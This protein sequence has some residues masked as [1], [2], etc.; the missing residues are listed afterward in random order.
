MDV[1]ENAAFMF[2]SEPKSSRNT[3]PRTGLVKPFYTS[4]ISILGIRRKGAS[5]THHTHATSNVSPEEG[6]SRVVALTGC[7]SHSGLDTC[8][9]IR[10]GRLE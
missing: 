6:E 2:P 8:L 5:P 4:I 7:S 1:T 9:R 3:L 10:T